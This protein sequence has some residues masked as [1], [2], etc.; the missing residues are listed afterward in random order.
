MAAAEGRPITFEQNSCHSFTKTSFVSSVKRLRNRACPRL[1]LRWYGPWWPTLTLAQPPTGSSII[2][3]IAWRILFKV[4]FVVLS[5]CHPTRSER[6]TSNCNRDWLLPPCCDVTS[7]QLGVLDE[8]D[9][10]PKSGNLTIYCSNIVCHLVVVVVST[11]SDVPQ[12]SSHT[13]GCW[14]QQLF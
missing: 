12:H 7:D 13:R 11:V 4:S 14:P 5:S 1:T 9:P 3:F 6:V 2:W 10:D 8:T